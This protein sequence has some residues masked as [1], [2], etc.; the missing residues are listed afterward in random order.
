MENFSWLAGGVVIGLVLDWT[1]L[2]TIFISFG[3][4]FLA[5]KSNIGLERIRAQFVQVEQPEQP[6]QPT[7]LQKISETIFKFY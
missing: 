3:L 5:A 6:T 7:T 4:G 2:P 1:S